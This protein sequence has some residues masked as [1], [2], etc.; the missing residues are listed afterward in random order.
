MRTVEPT[1]APKEGPFVFQR[2]DLALPVNE[3]F[4][5]NFFINIANSCQ[6]YYHYHHI[7]KAILAKSPL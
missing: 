5:E 3:T 4:T 1:A 6:N 7:V 2:A